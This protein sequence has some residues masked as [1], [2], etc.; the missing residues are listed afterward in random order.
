MGHPFLAR[1]E[2]VG[3]PYRAEEEVEGVGE[4]QTAAVEEVGVVEGRYRAN[5]EL[6]VRVV[7]E[8]GVVEEEEEERHIVVSEETFGFGLAFQGYLGQRLFV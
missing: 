7:G 1:V 5:L 8:A 2:A 4:L 6:E 3:V